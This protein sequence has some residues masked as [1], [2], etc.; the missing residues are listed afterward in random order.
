MVGVTEKNQFSGAG[1]RSQEFGVGEA[2]EETGHKR[3]KA[4]DRERDR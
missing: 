4:T 1:V 3:E 2:P